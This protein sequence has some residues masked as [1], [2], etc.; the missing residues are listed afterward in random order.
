MG[1]GGRKSSLADVANAR[2]N[3]SAH[4]VARTRSS[5]D[6]G[7][8][9]ILVDIFCVFVEARLVPCEQKFQAG[10]K[11]PHA[12]KFKKEFS[13]SMTISRCAAQVTC[14]KQTE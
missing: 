11:S 10:L 9:A 12:P 7:G 13:G 3:T 1:G 14:R 2:A 6:E 4:G 5:T 8:S